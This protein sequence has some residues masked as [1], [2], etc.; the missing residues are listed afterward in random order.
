MSG[1]S[2]VVQLAEAIVR[3]EELKI[4]CA[5]LAAEIRADLAEMGIDP[6]ERPWLR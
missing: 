1:Q 3:V 4:R 2:A 6:S 5:V